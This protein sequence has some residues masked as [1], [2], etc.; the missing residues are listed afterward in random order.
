MTRKLLLYSYDWAPLVGGVQTVTTDLARGICDWWK[1]HPEDK[2][3]VTLVT[4]TPAEGMDDSSFPFSIV[5][6]PGLLRLR[7]LMSAADV[8]HLAAPTALPLFLARLL[9]KP[10]AIEHHG[11]QA[12][13]PNGLLFFE[14]GQ[15]PCP[16][17]FMAGRY[18]KCVTCNRP[19]VG[20]PK[21]LS[22][23]VMTQMRRWMCNLGGINIVPTTWLGTVLRLRNTLTVYHGVPAVP[24]GHTPQ[25]FPAVI[26]FQGRLVST[27][28]VTILLAAAEQLQS[29]GLDFRLRIIGDGPE[30]ANLEA[31]A[32]KLRRGTVSFVGYVPPER[33]EKILADVSIVVMPSL[34]G[35]VF[36]LVVAE[37]MLRSKALV[38][39]DI[40]ALK[41]V[42]GDAGLVAPT[43]SSSELAAAL[44]RLLE[45]P[46][47]ASALG[48][49]ARERALALF[50]ID[51]MVERHLEIYK[52]LLN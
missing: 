17:H 51:K 3:E 21:T 8:V 38:V 33:F 19:G 37:N 11:F 30:R 32:G 13:C 34:G 49:Q 15:I 28:G 23:L 24:A 48:S 41:E 40:G 20:L 14:P 9:R 27:K 22:L 2:W 16:E 5:R 1:S 10:L 4:Q 29:E 47:Q 12:C 50:R 35:E 42:V 18:K 52:M 46:A 44:R 26:A 36:G 39:S 7:R 25:S 31:Q 45:N 6:R 43:G